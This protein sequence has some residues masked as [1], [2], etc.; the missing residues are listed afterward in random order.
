MSFGYTI[1][2]DERARGAIG[3]SVS[4]RRQEIKSKRLSTLKPSLNNLGHLF[5]SK[6][7]LFASD[8]QLTHCAQ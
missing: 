7:S 8:G 5:D 4:S 1:Q 3:V 6:S 2:P